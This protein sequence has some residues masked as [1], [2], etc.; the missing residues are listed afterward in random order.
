MAAKKGKG[1]R[2]TKAVSKRFGK[3]RKAAT[4][5]CKV[6]RNKAGVVTGASCK[7]PAKSKAKGKKSGK[8]AAARRAAKIRREEAAAWKQHQSMQGVKRRRKSRR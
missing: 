4:L 2:K 7:L 5:A 6:R 8:G 3:G 1:R